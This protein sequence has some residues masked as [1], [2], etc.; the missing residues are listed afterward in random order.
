[1]LSYGSESFVIKDTAADLLTG[2]ESE[3][4]ESLPFRCGKDGNRWRSMQRNRQ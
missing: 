4:P 1:M 3:D 2:N